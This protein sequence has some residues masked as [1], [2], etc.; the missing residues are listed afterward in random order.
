MPAKRH[1]LRPTVATAALLLALAA[2]PAAA[3]PDED[4]RAANALRVLADIQAI[5]E[6]AIPEKLFDEGRAIVVVPRSEELRFAEMCAARGFAAARIGVVDSG[7]GAESGLA[8]GAQALVV[9]GVYGESIVLG[10]DEVRAAREATFPALF[11]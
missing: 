8:S 3:G 11:G 10:L 7:I 9:D 1:L 4:A 2:A 6:S 5:P